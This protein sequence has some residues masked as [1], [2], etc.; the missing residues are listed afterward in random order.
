M[1]Q[2]QYFLG[3]EPVSVTMSHLLN[4]VTVR[5]NRGPFLSAD[6]MVFNFVATEL[7]QEQAEWRGKSFPLGFIIEE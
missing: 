6:L 4:T 3:E 2:W 7:D 5:I 1:R